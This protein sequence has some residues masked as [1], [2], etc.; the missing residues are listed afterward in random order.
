MRR[1]LLVLALASCQAYETAKQ[2]ITSHG[3]VYVCESGAACAGGQEEWCWSGPERELEQ[4]LG[5]ECHE[6]RLSER[7]WPAIVGCAFCCGDGC[8]RGCDAHCGC[9]CEAP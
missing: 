4:M 1:L 7:L 6:I 5:A 9:A 2:G 3:T 8:P